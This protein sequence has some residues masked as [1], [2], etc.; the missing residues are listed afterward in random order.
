MTEFTSGYYEADLVAGT[1]T[2]G[3]D[4][5]SLANPEEI[6]I[7]V[8][9]LVLYITTPA[10]GTPTADA[11]IAADGTTSAD[12]LID[13]IAIG[14]AAK[15]VSNI[16]DPGTNGGQIEWGADEYLTITPSASAAG[17]VG[18]AFVRYVR[19]SSS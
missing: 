5:L 4:V 12:N 17:L 10:T 14:D 13:G 2:A 15:V 6:D 11:G 9:E 18:K 1:T 7:V 3:G 16:T 19:P 8:T